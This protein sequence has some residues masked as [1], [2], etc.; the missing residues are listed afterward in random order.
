MPPEDCGVPWAILEFRERYSLLNIA[1][2][3]YELAKRRLDMG[4][5]AFVHDHSE[6]VLQLMRWLEIDRFDRGVVNR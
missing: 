6:E 2:R 5:E 1:D 3:L 4:S